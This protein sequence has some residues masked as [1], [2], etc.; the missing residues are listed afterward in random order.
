MRQILVSL[1]LVGVLLSIGCQSAPIQSEATSQ[2]AAATKPALQNQAAAE[3]SEA[4]TMKRK[5]QRRAV[6][7]AKASG[8]DER[9]DTGSKSAST[10]PEKY[11]VPAETEIPVRLIDA[12]STETNEVGDTFLASLVEPLTVNG[13]VLFAKDTSVQGKIVSLEEPGRVK[14]V[15]SISLQLTEIQ[16]GTGRPIPL[17]TAL[18]SETAKSEKKK[19]AAIIGGGAGIGTAIGALTGGKKGAA[20]GAIV[21]GGSGSGYVLAT[22]GKQLKYPSETL[23]T[24]RLAEPL[25]VTR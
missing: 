14:G 22:K 20:I 13:V 21:G 11:T 1:T 12:V 25:T 17:Q 9:S 8:L 16:P 10:A 7:S 2:D 3:D 6:K 4:A 19:D 15:A 5:R 18:F 23:I 24:F